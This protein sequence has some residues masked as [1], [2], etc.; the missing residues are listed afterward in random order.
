[1]AAGTASPARPITPQRTAVTIF[2]RMAI[3][4]YAVVHAVPLSVKL[5][6]AGLLVPVKVPLNPMLVL[7]PLGL[8]VRF[9]SRFVAVTSALPDA[10][11]QVALQPGGVSRWPAGWGKGGGPPGVSAVP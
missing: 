7:P 3:P 2:L 5:V 10:W 8:S 11:V 9:Q 6:G 1:M 4:P